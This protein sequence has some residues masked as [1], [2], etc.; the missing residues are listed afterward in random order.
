MCN[1]EG[2]EKVMMSALNQYRIHMNAFP[3]PTAAYKEKL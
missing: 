2:E 3:I 1:E